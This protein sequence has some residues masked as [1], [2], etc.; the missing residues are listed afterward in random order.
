MM[1]P[2]IDIPDLCDVKHWV[3]KHFLPNCLPAMFS[4]PASR[5]CVSTD[6]KHRVFDATLE[7]VKTFIYC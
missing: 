4:S 6:S 3:L 7:E 1:I 2:I 5:V